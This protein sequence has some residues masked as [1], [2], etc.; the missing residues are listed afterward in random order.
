MKQQKIEFGQVPRQLLTAPCPRRENPPPSAPPE[1]PLAGEGELLAT[2]MRIL[3]PQRA[4]DKKFLSGLLGA[5][6]PRAV[7]A[8]GFEGVVAAVLG[9]SFFAVCQQN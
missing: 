3:F 2:A 6:P 4:E 9:F 1:E 5:L 8:E 7:F